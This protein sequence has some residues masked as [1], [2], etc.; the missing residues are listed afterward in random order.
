MSR[1]VSMNYDSIQIIKHKKCSRGYS[2]EVRGDWRS[3]GWQCGGAIWV[4][5]PVDG[6]IVISDALMQTPIKVVNSMSE[7]LT[8]VELETRQIPELIGWQL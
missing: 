5:Q 4:A 3:N 2:F 8:F 1:E 6:G 7:F